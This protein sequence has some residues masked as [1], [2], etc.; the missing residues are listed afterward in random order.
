M[1]LD[2]A[3]LYADEDGRYVFDTKGNHT[4]TISTSS[5]IT[6]IDAGRSTD[7]NAVYN[8]MGV[9]VLDNASAADLELL[10]TGIYV[11]NGQKMVIR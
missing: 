10:P 9:K 1:K 7:N 5:S 11:V 2:D 8:L 3:T 4:V 6:G